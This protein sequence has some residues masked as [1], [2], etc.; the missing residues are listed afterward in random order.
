MPT[1]AVGLL[2][3]SFPLIY[4]NTDD[5]FIINLLLNKWFLYGVILFLS[6]LM[7]SNLPVMALKFKD[8]TIK[9]NL[10]KIIL[11]VVALVFAFV[12]QWL[13]V[14]FIFITYIILSLIFKNRL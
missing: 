13:A 9:N 10:P 1:P 7:I 2:I 12:I 14:P 4:W 11:F 8:G 6:W 5:P 3:A